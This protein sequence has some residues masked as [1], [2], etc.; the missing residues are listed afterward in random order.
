MD[1]NSSSSFTAILAVWGAILSTLAIGWNIYRDVRNSPRLD[2]KGMIGGYVPAAPG[3]RPS[4]LVLT[5][6]NIGQRTVIVRN[7]YAV[8]KGEGYYWR[9]QG[10]PIALKEAEYHIE[11]VD[12][13][14][15]EKTDLLY[16]AAA[17][18]TGKVW[19]LDGKALKTLRDDWE[20]IKQKE[21]SA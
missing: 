4:H 2:L 20:K 16:I 1:A 19:R 17:D 8:K 21:G 14:L 18:S 5:L 10:I 6:T 12:P 13:T 11:N 3:E 9:T 15:L 7:L